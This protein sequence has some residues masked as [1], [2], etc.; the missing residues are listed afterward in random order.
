MKKSIWPSAINGNIS[1][2]PSKSAAQRA[3][4]IAS[5]AKGDSVIVN[6]GSCDDVLSV[7]RICKSLGAEI[8]QSDNNLHI[9]GGMRPAKQTLNCGESG[10]CLRMF[11]GIAVTFDTPLVLTGSG[12]LLNRPLSPI[13]TALAAAGI[14]CTTTEGKLPIAI[15]GPLRGRTVRMDGSESSQVLTGILIASVFAESDV[16]IQVSVLKSKPYIDLTLEIMQHFGVT[17]ERKGYQSFQINKNQQY[18]GT[19]YDVEGDWSGASFI[20]VAGAVNGRVT[21]NKL[22]PESKQ[23]DK[24]ILRAL[25][26]AGADVQ[27]TDDGILVQKKHL[28]SF[29]FDATDCPDLFPPLA[30]LA[31]N[32]E[33]TSK[34]RGIGRL[35]TKESD[36][37]LSLTDILEKLGVKTTSKEDT[38]VIEGGR[39]QG[40]TIDAHSDHRIAMAAATAALSAT[41]PVHING[42]EAVNKSYPNFFSDLALIQT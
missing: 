19:R 22:H 35:R 15:Q 25:K 36:R 40:A 6:P 42:A 4:A 9:R 21:V 24:K 31:A 23:A 38:L 27:L 2:P 17:V 34:I 8:K 11:A 16:K 32:C 28:H 14:T 29:S 26:D 7:I 41:G 18:A 1:A 39:V 10:L 33:G 37:L 5:M 30:V 20:L 13:Q 3:I 12:T